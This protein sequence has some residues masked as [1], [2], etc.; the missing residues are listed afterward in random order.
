MSIDEL[1]AA[2]LDVRPEPERDR[3]GRYLL[4]DPDTGKKKG[5]TRATTLAK[6]LSD[7]F[8]LTKWELRM[9][10]VG[11]ARRPDLLAQVATVTDPD[12]SD[13][14]KLLD[15][16]TADAK[17]AAGS[18]VRRNLGTA[19]HAMCEHVDA[20]RDYTVPDAHRADVDA[21][22]E[23][24][25]D[26]GL[27]IDPA[28]IERICIVPHVGV[29]GTFD[30]LATHDG[31]LM[32]AD[33]KTGRSV[34]Y[35]MGEIAIQLA[36]YAHATHLWDHRTGTWEPMPTVDQERALVF[37][38]PA[39]EARC[40][41]LEV[42]IAAGWEMTQ[43]AIDVRAWRKR[44]D[45]SCVLTRTATEPTRVDPPAVRAPTTRDEWITGRI[46]TLLASTAAKRLLGER[47]PADTPKR[48]P[49]TGAQVDAIAPVLDEIETTVE[50]PFPHPDPTKPRPDE[51]LTVELRERAA[52]REAEAVATAPAPAVDHLDDGGPA[53]VADVKALTARIEELPKANRQTAKGWT[54][55]GRIAGRPWGSTKAMSVRTHALIDAATACAAHLYDPERPDDLTRAAL[56]L[57]LDDELQPSWRTGALI[58]S[59]TIDEAHRLASIAVAFGDDDTKTVQSLGA[60]VTQLH[61]PTETQTCSTN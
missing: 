22:R 1:N 47:W 31:R 26:A 25:A 24:V 27:T 28:H 3:W 12:D 40:T 34:D 37:H 51:A 17:E 2:A 16:L 53:P 9:A 54:E 14:K 41:V 45:L 55:E 15:T 4:P 60:T 42:D 58:G 43:V 18:S 36:L 29:A 57:V 50:A 30:R 49:W 56:T 39:G 44:R 10:A 32:V 46:D 21:Y 35:G 33:L 61:T 13:A 38:L 20:G 8:A 59:L 7:T 5:W 11:L 52:E 48:A 19:L 23:A 6:T